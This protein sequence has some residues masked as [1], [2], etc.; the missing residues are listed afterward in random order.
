M[1]SNFW[2]IIVQMQSTLNVEITQ[3]YGPL[4]MIFPSFIQFLLRLCRCHISMIPMVLLSRGL[5][6]VLSLQS[7]FL[8]Q[9]LEL[10]HSMPLKQ[11]TKF[12]EKYYY[13]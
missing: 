2:L 6:C 9:R 3:R 1:I 4:L 8:F 13:S 5:D 10:W 11:S 7:T 12:Y